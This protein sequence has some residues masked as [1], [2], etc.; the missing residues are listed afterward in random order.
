MSWH[1]RHCKEENDFNDVIGSDLLTAHSSASVRRVA[2]GV[3]GAGIVGMT[4]AD[5]RGWEGD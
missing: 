1:R 4:E 3:G 2:G 5:K